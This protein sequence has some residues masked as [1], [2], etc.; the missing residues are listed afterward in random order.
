[1][2]LSVDWLISKAN[3]K[4][5]DTG[6]LAAV[7]DKTRAVIKKLAAEG[8]YICVAQGYRSKADQDTL[9]ALGRTKSGKIVTNARGGQSNHNFGVAVDLCL[10]S[11]DGSSVSWQTGGLFNKV[12]AAMKAEGFKWGGDWRSFKDNP[13]FELY[14]AAGGEK[15]PT[16]VKKSV[17]PTKPKTSKKATISVVKFPGIL[18]QGSKGKDVQ[19]VQNAVGVKADGKFGPATKKAVQAYQKRHGLVADG[20]IGEKT[21]GVMF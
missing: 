8:I 3:R 13:H 7:A 11:A 4:L 12:V 10:Y 15:A 9:Y 17:K 6:M 2:T 20:I 16:A 19:R 5:D 14:D 21:W 18:K 1:M